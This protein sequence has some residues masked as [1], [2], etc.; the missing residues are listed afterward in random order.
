MR[1][2]WYNGKTLDFGNKI[3]WVRILFLHVWLGELGQIIQILEVSLSFWMGFVR[4]NKTM[5][6][7]IEHGAWHRVLVPLPR[8]LP[9]LTSSLTMTFTLEHKMVDILK[10]TS[11]RVHLQKMLVTHP[12]QSQALVL[13]CPWSQGHEPGRALR[14]ILGHGAPVV[15][16]E[17]GS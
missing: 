11:C 7:N 2:V 6:E 16:V 9:I 10:F 4:F 12:A 3:I 13:Q 15:I 14:S 17:V 8:P 5:Y 1:I